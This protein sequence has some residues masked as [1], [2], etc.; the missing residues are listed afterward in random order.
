MPR[1]ALVM[2]EGWLPFTGLSRT[3]AS[4]LNEHLALLENNNPRSRSVNVVLHACAST[5]DKPEETPQTGFGDQSR[6]QISIDW[7]VHKS[8]PFDKVQTGRCKHDEQMTT[9]HISVANNIR[10]GDLVVPDDFSVQS[11]GEIEGFVDRHTPK[12]D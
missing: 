11:G 4:T 7:S 12:N 3:I 2:S 8:C 6:D 10:L 9:V 5:V 1:L